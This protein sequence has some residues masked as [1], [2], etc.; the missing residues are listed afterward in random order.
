[1]KIIIILLFLIGFNTFAHTQLVENKSFNVMLK[2]LLSH[3]VKE[4]GVKEESIDSNTLFLDAREYLEYNVSHLKN[5]VWVGY[6][7]FEISRVKNIAKNKKIV[8]YCSVGYRS[9]KIT[10]KLIKAGYTN[11]F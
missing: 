10:E 7:D 2:T 11:I 8:V 9:E 3:N 1:M 6:N 4:L 5:S